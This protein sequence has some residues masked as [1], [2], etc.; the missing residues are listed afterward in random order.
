MTMYRVNMTMPHERQTLIAD[1]I[2]NSIETHTFY[3]YQNKRSDLPVIRF[4]IN[5]PNYR[6]ANF[7]T[8][9]AQLKYV[10]E[11][12]VLEDFFTSGQ[13]NEATQRAQHDILVMFAEQG[14][15]SSIAPIMSELETDGQREPLLITGHGV[16]VNGNRR[17]AAM[18]ELF[19]RDPS[20]FSHFSHVDCAVLPNNVTPGEVLEI[21]VRLQMRAETKLPYGWIE[22]SIA[23]REMLL[24]GKDR[25]HVAGLM[26]KKA[27]EVET[28]ER[29]LT[30]V[31]IYLKEWIREPNN[32]E[33]VEDAQQFFNDL[34]KALNGVEGMM[35]EIKRRIAWALISNAN[36]LEGRI[37]GYK[38]S[39]EGQT[40]EVIA[41]LSERLSIDHTTT[42]S[43]KSVDEDDEID[44]DFGDNENGS[45]SSLENLVDAFDDDA[46]REAVEN[47]LLDVCITINERNRQRGVGNQALSSIRTA[48]TK[49]MSVDLSKAEPKTYRSIGA[50]LS[51]IK[52]RVGVLENALQ[53]YS[54]TDS[55]NRE[56]ADG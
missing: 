29:A 55:L 8:R 21:E 5:L 49:L 31:D 37:Y 41:A 14:R 32:Y 56:N 15:A 23:I 50:Q 20:R 34:A 18:R 10:H 19:A 24:G 45:G 26:K 39:F 52:S 25:T 2:D 16:V 48:N 3:E 1:A 44:I 28:A 43:M 11:R 6:M 36:R 46:Q 33:I 22:E 38:F 54:S 47:E 7:R 12:G 35:L 17:L 40:E 27:K 30:E 42:K 51:A 53:K 4:D 9:T 13:E